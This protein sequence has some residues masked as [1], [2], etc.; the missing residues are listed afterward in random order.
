M[1]GK[2]VINSVRR[3]PDTD[4]VNIVSDV[5]RSKYELFFGSP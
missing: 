1:Y 5:S 3:Q 2:S 4:S